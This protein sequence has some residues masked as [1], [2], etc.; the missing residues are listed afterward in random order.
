MRVLGHMVTRNE[1]SRYL[2]ESIIHLRSIVDD[3]FVWDDQSDDGTLEYLRAVDVE[4]RR[5]RDG[6]LSFA[7]HEGAFRQAGWDAL[8]RT[9]CPTADDWI[10]CVDAD[11]FLVTEL[12]EHRSVREVLDAEIAATDTGSLTFPVAEVF[13]TD[14]G[15]PL[16]R[17]DGFW[18]AISACR[19]VRWRP[20]G[21]FRAEREGCGSV[22]D[23]WKR[24]TRSELTLLHYGYARTRDRVIK[25]AR[26]SGGGHHAGHVASILQPPQLE[27]WCGDAPVLEVA[28]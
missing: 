20:A 10:L 21:L 17:H 12:G 28:P 23:D 19:A 2:A 6:Q 14:R 22:P 25:H 26:Y 27:P 24:T 16:V 13:A 3:L 15:R 18:G 8:G 4:V 7:E 11:E 1:F 5:R 9:L